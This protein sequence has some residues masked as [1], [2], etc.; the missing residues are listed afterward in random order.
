MSELVIKTVLSRL[1]LRDYQEQ[2]VRAILAVY[3]DLTTVKVVS[4][5]TGSG[6]TIVGVAVAM[7]LIRA[8]Y[9]VLWTCKSWRLLRMAVDEFK[10]H[11]PESQHFLRRI[12]GASER[13]ELGHLPDGPGGQI[14]FTTI[15]SW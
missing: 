1:Q 13:F 2:A 14:Y 9:K 4:L 8:G 7:C 5:P 6:K 3:C 10:K 11:F 12:G 15:Q